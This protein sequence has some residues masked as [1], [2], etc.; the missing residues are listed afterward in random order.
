MDFHAALA[1]VTLT[2]G[3]APLAT[4]VTLRAYDERHVLRWRALR[5]ASNRAFALARAL[6]RAKNSAQQDACN[7]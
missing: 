4:L 1:G 2:F 6:N 7:D 5:Y 3:V